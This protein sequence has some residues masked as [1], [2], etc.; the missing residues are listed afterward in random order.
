MLK[1]PSVGREPTV[2]LADINETMAVSGM[3]LGG[4]V[5]P[6]MIEVKIVIWPRAVAGIASSLPDAVY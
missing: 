4:L 5:V 3:I 1:D 6:G 2:R